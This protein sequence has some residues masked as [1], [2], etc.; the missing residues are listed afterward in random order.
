VFDEA[1]ANSLLTISRQTECMTP[2]AAPDH[3][4]RASHYA[5][6]H[7]VLIRYFD[8]D[9]RH[10]PAGAEGMIGRAQLHFARAGDRA[11]LDR[12]AAI[13][14]ALFRLRQSLLARAETDF[15]AAER[16]LAGLARDWLL[17]APMFPA[18]AMPARRAA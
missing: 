18:E 4:W 2:S 15:R 16:E 5:A 13:S 10:P 11:A 1:M 6:V 14:I 17:K 3:A 8:S 12:L 9:A 7:D